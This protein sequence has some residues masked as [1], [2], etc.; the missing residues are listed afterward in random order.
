MI[1][2]ILQMNGINYKTMKYINKQLFAITLY[3]LFVIALFF[4]AGCGHSPENGKRVQ[5][6]IDGKIVCEG[7][8]VGGFGRGDGREDRVEI[9]ILENGIPTDRKFS[10]HHDF[11]KELNRLEK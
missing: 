8:V 11:I 6:I 3:F 1:M 7:I 4:L 10:I 5:V 9:L 2:A